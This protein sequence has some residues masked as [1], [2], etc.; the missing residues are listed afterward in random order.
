M[1][2]A[3][4]MVCLRLERGNANLLNIAGGLAERFKAEAIGVAARQPTPFVYSDSYVPQELVEQDR[5]AIKNSVKL[6]EE[7]FRTALAGRASGLRWRS[8]IMFGPLSD[9]IADE[10][11][12]ADLL[13]ISGDPE[14]SGYDPITDVNV[15]D[16][17]M[18]AGRPILV[19]P[20]AHDHFDLRRAVVG[21]KDTRETRRAI[22]DAVPLLRAAEQ[23]SVV[24]IADRDDLPDA[25]VRL[26]EVVGWLGR[27][28]VTAQAVASPAKGDD[29]REL[30]AIVREQGADLIVAGA[31]GHSRLREW[32]FG[33]VTRALLRNPPACLLLSH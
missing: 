18:R 25:R 29:A 12:G 10:A 26:D 14:G 32:V 8:S 23:V 6:A 21:W 17:A 13:L 15:G 3:T 22:V 19:T 24:E 33:G 16:L 1:T 31:Y 5:E 2:Y 4:L 28:G 30:K 20:D 7:E 11:R 27:H 9:Y